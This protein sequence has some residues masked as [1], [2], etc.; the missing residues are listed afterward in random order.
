MNVPNESIE[1]LIARLGPKR[2]GRYA[3]LRPHVEF[4]GELRSNRASYDTIVAILRERQG[5]EVSDTTVIRLT[6]VDWSGIYNVNVT[7]YDIPIGNFTNGLCQ[8]PN[9]KET[10]AADNYNEHVWLGQAVGTS[11]LGLTAPAILSSDY[12]APL[13]S[14]QSGWLVMPF[15]DGRA[16]LKQNLIFQLR[17][18]VADQPFQYSVIFT[19]YDDDSISFSSPTTYAY[20][21]YFYFEEYGDGYGNTDYEPI[22][23]VFQPFEEN[24]FDRNFVFNSS[25]LN[26]YG[27]TT[28]GVGGAYD[29]YGDGGLTAS[30]S[31]PEYIYNYDE[32]P[33]LYEFAEPTTNGTPISS[34]LATNTT[35]WLSTYALD[36]SY[37]YLLEIGVTNNATASP[38]TFT[39]YS[40]AK[41]Y[42]G[43]PF[44]S[45]AVGYGS[46]SAITLSAGSTT[47][48]GGYFYPETAQ[49]QLS[50]V[51]YDYW[52]TPDYFVDVFTNGTDFP[53]MAGLSLTHTNAL[54]IT[55]VGNA[56]F[57]ISCYAKMAVVNAYSG[58]YGYLQQYFD[59]A[60]EVTNGI[61][62]TNTTGIL[63]SYGNFFATE[64]GEAALVTMPDVDTGQRG[65]NIVYA[66]K[67]Q[68]DANHDGN[69]DLSFGGTDSGN[70]V[71]WVNNNFDRSHTVDFS[72]TEQD[73]VLQGED[74][75]SN[76]DPNDPDY[77]YKDIG[78][79]R[80]I[81]CTRDLEDFARLWVCGFTPDLYSN[82]PAGSTVT[83]SWGDVGSPNSA[84]PTIDVFQS[85]EGDGGIGYL[86]NET[87]ATEQ[88]DPSLHLYVQRLAPGGSIQ[89]SAYTLANAV[90][91]S[92]FIWCGV[93]NGSG[94]LT[95]TIADANSNV[96][97]QT[98]ANIQLKDIKQM[99]ERW[100]AG[101]NPSVAPVSSPI[102]ASD[103]LPPGTSAFQYTPPQ[104][105]NTP[106][107]LFVHGWNQPPW[108]KDRFAE[109]AFKRLY[110]QGFQGRFGEFRWPTYYGFP[111]GEI[112]YQ[113][114]NLRNF[115]NSEFNA[116]NSG[117]SLLN[118][119]GNLN[120]EYPRHVYLIAH[121]QGNIVA[122]EALRQ[123]GTNQVV[124]TYVAMQ[125][126]VPSHAY[127]PTTPTRALV[128]LGINLDSG[129]PDRYAQYYTNGAPCYFNSSAGAGTYVNFFNTNDWAL[130][131]LWQPDENIKPDLGYGY[132]GTNFTSGFFSTTDLFFPA[133]TYEIF[134]FC[135]EARSY[136]LGAQTGV[137]GTFTTS[138]QI[139]LDIAPYN[140]LTQH[141]Y[142]SGEFRSDNAQRW[143]FWDTTL[144]QMRLK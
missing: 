30:I 4:I 57:P 48:Q 23:D 46:G 103:S 2:T 14:F 8:L 35:R 107:I 41:N 9:T 128:T 93:T 118:L 71:F 10:G 75:F 117:T 85:V 67:L 22:L 102:L 133:N 92:H 140:F 134:S 87:T 111:A 5:I 108:E 131:T 50:L 61:V 124:N 136:A 81:P 44:L 141:K 13:D 80:V 37:N 31:A 110:W 33:L 53:G 70:F 54:L 64:P 97:G 76:L 51:E 56:Y 115:D 130:D 60:Y 91:G 25:Q 26:S 105:T 62:T 36:S 65:T 74:D 18:A 139:E 82:L 90:G 96:L 43:L 7:N 84:N 28:T 66:L 47:T 19:N 73:D 126:A 142:H 94:S 114:V 123:A 101:D 98:S 52:H 58:V 89:L 32:I 99:Y 116:W 69:M 119:L 95:L 20:A 112:S 15:F 3:A 34:V 42:F 143:Q 78:G 88:I 127:D 16:Q 21:G 132:D 129:T 138:K 12:S 29:Y 104:D 59:K 86:T 72:D 120:T 27:R 6:E 40:N 39:M 125:A 24:Y 144:V 1:Q 109:T 137:G 49:P 11:G 79:N 106:Y 38:Q 17:A 122:G 113:S 121:S 68:L 55:S 77:D 135:D 100:T 63:S 45:A 83:L